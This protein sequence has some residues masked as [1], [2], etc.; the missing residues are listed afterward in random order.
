MKP[1]VMYHLSN[2]QRKELLVRGTQLRL[3]LPVPPHA[4]DDPRDWA[5]SV[6]T[7]DVRDMVTEA[8][9]TE[10]T[11]SAIRRTA[12]DQL[13]S[14]LGEI[15]DPDCG[16]YLLTVVVILVTLRPPNCRHTSLAPP[17]WPMQVE[18]RGDILP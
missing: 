12:N 2:R 1:P 9:E 15:L 11:V 16:Q 13:V 6:L 3:A 17:Q 18:F 10:L 5:A 4:V 7:T 14:H 8:E